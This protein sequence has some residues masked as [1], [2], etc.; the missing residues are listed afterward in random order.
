[1]VSINELK[2][3]VALEMNYLFY[4]VFKNVSLLVCS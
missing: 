2:R 3:L 4:L 1:M